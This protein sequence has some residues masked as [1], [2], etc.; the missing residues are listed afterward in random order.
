MKKLLIV[1]STSLIIGTNICCQSFAN[2]MQNNENNKIL[3]ENNINNID[4][5]I[6]IFEEP[7]KKYSITNIN[8]YQEPNFES[9]IIGYLSVN[10][11]INVVCNDFYGWSV[12]QLDTGIQAYVIGEYLSNTPI[13][14]NR[15]KIKL[16]PEEFDILA[17][18]TMLEAGGEASLGQ[19]AVV[20]V[21]LNRIIDPS[22]PNTL[23]E[24]LSEKG[25]FTPWKRINSN[26]AIPTPQ[27][28]LSVQQV[29]N[30]ETN[31]LPYNT[32]YFS[33]KAQNK[34]IQTKIGGHV[35]CNK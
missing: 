28:I 15:W 22:F 25:Q 16:T 29:L 1:L 20:E 35:F 23:I 3:I 32:V 10:T 2:E 11:P 26:S 21:I 34:R 13:V 4:D 19:Q 31:I 8:I 27:V 18:I 5:L 24:V 30:G 17:R 6:F 12:I 7:V 14:T 33:R 9:Q